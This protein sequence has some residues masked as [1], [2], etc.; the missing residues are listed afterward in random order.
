M[1]MR[2][3][4][5]V[6]GLMA[7]IVLATGCP[8][9]DTP[10]P[11]AFDFDNILNADENPDPAFGTA[12]ASLNYTGAIP[13]APG[14]AACVADE[15]MFDI[16]DGESA[17]FYWLPEGAEEYQVATIIAQAFPVGNLGDVYIEQETIAS[18]ITV[19][20]ALD[21]N[22][23][24]E[25]AP[26]ITFFADVVEYQGELVLMLHCYSNHD[27]GVGSTITYDFYNGIIDHPVSAHSE[28][29]ADNLYED[30]C[31]NQSKVDP[32]PVY[33]D[34]MLLELKTRRLVSAEIAHMV[35]FE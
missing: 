15:L 6:V 7:V 33:R 25:E 8:K 23:D 17:S 4:C 14:K 16:V 31:Y 24:N 32:V 3:L 11:F 29:F 28:G 35:M 22:A 26:G 2:N 18:E 20:A 21:T 30:Q 13:L 1:N 5:L 9:P 19:G 12:S 10:D 27:E 34:D